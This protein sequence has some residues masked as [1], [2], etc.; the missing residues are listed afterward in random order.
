MQTEGRVEEKHVPKRV[1][2]RALQRGAHTAEVNQDAAVGREASS[3]SVFTPPW[4]D[5]RGSMPD[6]TG[7]PLSDTVR[8]LSL[9]LPPVKDT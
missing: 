1:A 3:L 4:L 6:R 5:G 2:R 8:P 7:R 9:S